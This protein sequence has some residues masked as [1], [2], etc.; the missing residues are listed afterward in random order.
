MHQPRIRRRT[1]LVGAFA[2]AVA[3][4]RVFDNVLAR[5]RTLTALVDTVLDTPDAAAATRRIVTEYDAALPSRRQ[6]TDD[7][8]DALQNAGFAG[9]PRAER[10]AFLRTSPLGDRAVA[11]RASGIGPAGDDYRSAPVRLWA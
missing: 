2:L 8:I 1:L 3:G 7:V 6:A 5:R 4:P 11:L 9:K 10:V